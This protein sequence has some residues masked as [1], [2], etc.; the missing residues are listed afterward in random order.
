MRIRTSRKT[1]G[2]T[3]LEIMVALFLL[4][5]IVA[6]IYSSWICIM[7]GTRSGLKA[8]AEAQR[9]RIAIQTLEEA[10]NS[11]GMFEA[12]RESYTFK[13]ETGKA[14][15]SFVARLPK[16]FPRS[17]RFGDLDV[18]RV[19]FSVE[20]SSAMDQ[21][22][23][24][25]LRQSSMFMEP[26]VD[27][28]EHPVVLAKNVRKFETEFWDDKDEEWINEWTRTNELPRMVKINLQVSDGPCPH[29][30]KSTRS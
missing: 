4:S 10:L 18:R 1:R 2:F 16:S 22:D 14:Y 11:A 27:E 28:Q 5:F 30:R 12:D 7:R 24:L 6:A 26:D 17:G 3:L 9:S 15:L 25:V 29:N 19:E 23:Q 21:G 13:T 20:P 8:A